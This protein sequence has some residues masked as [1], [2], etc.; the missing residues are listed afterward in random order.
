MPLTSDQ[1]I[2]FGTL[3]G[4]FALFLWGPFRY[5]VVAMLALLAVVLTGLVPVDQAFLGFAHPAVIT[6]AAVLILSRSL[7][8]AG[9]VDVIIRLLTPLRGSETLQVGSQAGL[10][11]LLS[12]FMNNVGALALML[13]VALRNA[14]RDGYAP[15]SS[16]MPLAFASL[17]GGMV[18]LIGTPPNLIIASF[19]ERELGTPFGMFDFTPVGGAV[20]IAGLAFIV[21]AGSRLLPT[22][23]RGANDDALNIGDYL[24]EARVEKDGEAWGKSLREIEKLV[25]GEVRIVGLVHGSK[26]QMAPASTER[27]HARHVLILEGEPA[28]IK[29]LVDVGGLKLLSSEGLT[30]EQLR[31]EKVGLAEA[32][33]KP[34]SSLEG[35]TPT[36]LNLRRDHGINLLG[37]ARH[38]KRVHKR[39]GD[40]RL[41]TGDVL[42][43]QGPTKTMNR[44]LAEL[45][46]LPLAERSLQIGRPRRL[47]LAGG[48][49]ALAI[50]ATMTGLVPVQLAFVTAAV[51][52]VLVGI[53]RPGEIYDSVDWPVIVLL[54]AMIPVGAALETTGGAALVAEGILALGSNLASVWMV[55]LLL[56]GTMFLSDAINNNA[57]AVLMAPIGLQMAEHLQASP[58]PFLMAVAVGASCAF[59]TPIGHQSNTLIMAPGGYH[60][61]D[62]WRL[63]LPLELIIVVVAVP[64]IVLVWPL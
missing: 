14:Y 36:S 42:L 56:V 26:R 3:L 20:A 24:A 28:A 7:Q 63:G 37:I 50:L 53:V 11:A 62:Y 19:R 43:L 15:A 12:G 34:G 33:I 6:V 29:E 8:N 17:L 39:L 58:D 48:I 31:S 52:V 25:D 35:K 54:G 41:Q 1:A 32:V 5:D 23:R 40:I 51:A 13:P 57:T 16:L 49:L 21:L 10:I 27:V 47:L 60:F 46:C 45:G 4:A 9:I 44:T 38:G 61:G 22:D 55:M 18:T 2:A 30:A 59:L 64:M